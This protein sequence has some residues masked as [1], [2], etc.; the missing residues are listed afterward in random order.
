MQENT[1]TVN[2][3]LAH[4]SE[5]QA[6]KARLLR[7][8]PFVLFVLAGIIAVAPFFS[9]TERSP[10]NNEAVKMLWTDDLPSHFAFSKQF[11]KV[12][13]SG[14]LYPRWLS[15]VNKGYGIATTI[16][17]PPGLNY[18]ALLV[19]ALIGDW[20]NAFFVI[21]T[22]ALVASGLSFYR[23]SRV[24]FSRPASTIAAL[25]YMLFP[26][27]LF[28]LYF[29]GAVPQFIG[30]AFMP[31]MIYFAY[32]LG[33]QGRLI[34]YA[35][36]GLIYGLYVMTH[37]PVSYLFT[38]AL[39]LYAVLWAVR[40]R[41]IRIAF[42][43]A[44]GMFL[45]LL[46]SAIYWLP[47]ALESKYVYEWASEI[48]P[49]HSTYFIGLE[50][51]DTFWF[52]VNSSFWLII[53]AIVVAAWTLKTAALE[54]EESPWQKKYPSDSAHAHVRLWIILAISAT[55]MSTSFSLHISKLIPRIDVATPAWRWLAISTVFASLALAAAIER[56]KRSVAQTSARDWGCRA[57]VGI[58]F[59]LS[60]WIT[61]KY[62][63]IEPVRT[64]QSYV[65]QAVHIDSGFTPKNS[66]PPDHLPDTPLAVLEPDGGVGE[67]VAWDPQHREIAV[68]V[69]QPSELRLKTYNFPGWTARIDG[70]KVPVS[71]DKDGVQIISVPPGRH[72][73][74]A[75]FVNTPPRT[76]GAVLF[77]V[78]LTA[79][80]CLTIVDYRRTRPSNSDE[81]GRR[82]AGAANYPQAA[83]L[84][85]EQHIAKAAPKKRTRLLAMS[86]ALAAVVVIF[87]VIVSRWLG[88]RGPSSG[89]T[90]AAGA[91]ASGN[92]G[93]GIN[94][95]GSEGRLS[96]GSMSSIP[97]AVDQKALDE[98]MNVLPMGNDDG[99]EELIRSGRLFR[100]TSNTRVRVLEYGSA[101]IKVRILEGDSVVLDGWVPERWIR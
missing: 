87:T 45:G 55:F 65:I 43:I 64:R 61:V 80:A 91:A 68:R 20:M 59:V 77:F 13:R 97:V 31:W 23:L 17:Y 62:G 5:E 92:T 74:E 82:F 83:D 19:H 95:V 40:E 35:G 86:L 78:G 10:I 70:Q 100:V 18:L 2:T 79:I 99:V 75:D 49:Y 52:L 24:F 57:A 36:L 94:G 76:L 14:V 30:Y 9:R 6:L 89:K 48:M 72:L 101:A 47:A 8:L 88:P 21:T 33:T 85:A 11:D 69:D 51:T 27:H 34:H 28:N 53:A 12:F 42:R 60:L 63:I 50:S 96:A 93:G 58:L 15:D 32:R 25:F 26:F 73:I 38:Y 46:V 41:N 44:V 54:G 71:S 90:P 39:A 1:E 84:I 16:F 3:P 29:Q 7:V 37:L 98:L 67:V 66:T 81:E 56:V 4:P 22:L